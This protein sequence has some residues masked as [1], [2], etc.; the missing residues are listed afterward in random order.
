MGYRSVVEIVMYPGEPEDFAMLKLY[1][2]E[3][4]PDKFDVVGSDRK[5]LHLCLGGVKWYDSYEE[6][7]VYTQCFANW[8]EMFGDK[9]HYEFIRIGEE[10]EDIEHKASDGAEYLLQVSTTIEHNF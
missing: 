1:V 7:S 5:V 2:D 6:V 3:S 4:L 9:C 8:D 10:T